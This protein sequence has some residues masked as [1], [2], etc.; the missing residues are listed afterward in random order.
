ML[1]CC[2]LQGSTE[3]QREGLKSARV[4]H[5][6]NPG[7]GKSN[8]PDK[9]CCTLLQESIYTTSSLWGRLGHN[10]ALKGLVPKRRALHALSLWIMQVWAMPHHF[11]LLLLLACCPVLMPCWGA[12][13]SAQAPWSFHIGILLLSSQH[14]SQKEGLE[15]WPICWRPSACIIWKSPF[16]A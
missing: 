2:T 9:P 16:A 4:L 5:W 15:V 6:A 10:Q 1:N 8:L 14:Y 7:Q 12:L 11:L 3:A 13:S